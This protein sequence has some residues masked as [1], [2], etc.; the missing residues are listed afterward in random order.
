MVDICDVG[1]RIHSENDEMIEGIA[2]TLM[3]FILSVPFESVII[4]TSQI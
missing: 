3:F 1:A 4:E 2:K